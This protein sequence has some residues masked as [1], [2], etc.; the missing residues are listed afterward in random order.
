MNVQALEFLA[1][2]RIR[3]DDGGG[4]VGL[5]KRNFYFLDAA[6]FEVGHQTIYKSQRFV[7][8]F[9]TIYHLPHFYKNAALTTLRS[10]RLPEAPAISQRASAGYPRCRADQ[11]A[12]PW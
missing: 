11:R 9:H 6:D 2:K 1:R 3:D 12:D 5:G 7:F 4:G 10:P 8:N